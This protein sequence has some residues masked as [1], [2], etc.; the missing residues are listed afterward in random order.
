MAQKAYKAFLGI[1]YPDAE[2]YDCQKT[3]DSFPVVFQ[4]FAYILHDKDLGEDG[5]LKKP[6]FHWVGRR[7]PAPIST[8]SNAL[9]V[10]SNYIEHCKSF[11]ASIRYLPHLDDPDKY[12]YPI[13][14]V[15]GSFPLRYLQSRVEESDF[16]Q[17]A[18]EQVYSNKIFSMRQL[19][20]LALQQGCWPDFRRNYSILRDALRDSSGVRSGWAGGD[21]LE[22]K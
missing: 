17:M 1:L 12:Q 5:E 18:L 14:S 22:Q 16:V 15:Q 2:N 20:L 9:G 7:T 10:P 6:H 3:L 8:I 11:R 13:E 4:E 21:S 19:Q